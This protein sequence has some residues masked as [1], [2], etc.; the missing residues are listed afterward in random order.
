MCLIAVAWRSHPRYPLAL[1][2]N[3]DELHARP[4][5]AADFDPDA[6][7]IYGGRD[8][9]EGGSWLQVSTRR[10]LA[11]VT[12]VRT[13]LRPE[14]RPR[15]RGR[16]VRD[17]VRGDVGAIDY[18]SSLER[19]GDEYGPFNLLLWVGAVLAFASN[20]PRPVHSPVSPGLHAMSNGASANSADAEWRGSNGN[21]R[22][23]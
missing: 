1:I 21:A 2:A 10:Q 13:G 8:L 17:F 23:P 11:A 12:N 6:P 14:A 18:V 4:A 19:T 9:V 5:A 16:L 22:T 7:G 20:Y 15:S 3:R